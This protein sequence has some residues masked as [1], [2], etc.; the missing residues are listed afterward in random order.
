MEGAFIMSMVGYLSTSAM[1][2]L[3]DCKYAILASGGRTGGRSIVMER[4]VG[5]VCQLASSL[6]CLL[7]DSSTEG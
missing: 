4:K 2:M 3:I 1:L 5:L 7:Y 6:V